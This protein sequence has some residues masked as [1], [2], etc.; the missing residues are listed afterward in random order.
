MTPSFSTMP[1]S[2]LQLAC[3]P[4]DWRRLLRAADEGGSDLW[5]GWLREN[6]FASVAWR[7]KR[8]ERL[9]LDGGKC[10]CCGRVRTGLEVHHKSLAN[11]GDED[12]AADLET[13]C[14]SCHAELELE[15]ELDRVVEDARVLRSMKESI[16][17]FTRDAER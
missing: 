5:K 15:G 10:A 17:L 12:V 16:R 7:N 13:R 8:E 4:A 9:T 1:N 6:Y 11:F 2:L 14:R 3:G